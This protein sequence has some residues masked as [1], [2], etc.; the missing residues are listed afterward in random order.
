MVG[1]EI[2]SSKVVSTIA[3]VESRLRASGRGVLIF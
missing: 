3:A 1:L 2:Q